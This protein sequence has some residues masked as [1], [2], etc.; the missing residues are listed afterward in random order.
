M[1]TFNPSLIYRND[2]LLGKYEYNIVQVINSKFGFV[3]SFVGTVKYI[4]LEGDFYYIDSNSDNEDFVPLNNNDV[5]STYIDTLVRVTGVIAQDYA[6]IY[7]FGTHI[8]ILSI[9]LEH[10]LPSG[11]V[12]E[13]I[14]SRKYAVYVPTN[15]SETNEN[16]PLLMNFHGYDDEIENYINTSN[17]VSLSEIHNFILVYP[18]G[19]KDESGKYHWNSSPLGDNNKSDSDDL[20]FFDAVVA[21]VSK[22]YNIDMKRIYA[23]GFSNGGGFVHHLARN[24]KIAAGVCVSGFSSPQVNNPSSSVSFMT[25]HGTSDSVVPYNGSEYYESMSDVLTYWSNHNNTVDSTETAIGNFTHY[26]YTSGDNNT[27]VEHYK[28]N[29]GGHVWDFSKYDFD[30]NTTVVEFLLQYNTDGAINPPQYDAIISGAG[31]GGIMAAVKMKINDPNLNVLVLEQNRHT[32]EEYKAKSYDLLSNWQNAMNDSEFMRAEQSTDQKTLWVGEGNGGGTLHFGLQYIDQTDI[33]NQRYSN[34]QPYF[35]EV[36]NITNAQTYNYDDTSINQNWKELKT[37]LENESGFTTYN[38][39]IYSSDAGNAKVNRLLLGD[40]LEQYGIGIKYNCSVS[41]LNTTNNIVSSVVTDKGT[42]FADKFILASGALETPKILLRS[43]I[44]TD[45]G[46]SLYDHAGCTF[47]YAKPVVTQNTTTF[48]LND[49]AITIIKQNSGRLVSYVPDTRLPVDDQNKVWDFTGFASAHPGGN[50]FKSNTVQMNLS[51]NENNWNKA[52]NNDGSNSVTFV[53][54]YNQVMYYDDLPNNLKSDALAIALG[55]SS[56]TY[57]DLGLEP[58]N[59]IGHIQTRDPGYKWQTYYSLIPNTYDVEPNENQILIVTHAQCTDLGGSGNLNLTE[60]NLNHSTA[61]G[62]TIVSHIADAYNKNNAILNNLGYVCLEAQETGFDLN[63]FIN[64]NLNSIYHYHGTCKDIVNVDHKVNN[65]DNLYIGDA[66]VLHSPWGGSTSVPSAVAGYIAGNIASGGNRA[67]VPI[68]S[69]FRISTSVDYHE[70]Y[71]NDVIELTNTI[72]NH[73]VDKWRSVITEKVFSNKDSDLNLKLKFND[74]DPSQPLLL[75]SA[76][77]TPYRDGYYYYDE[78]NNN[79]YDPG[80]EIEGDLDVADNGKIMVFRGTLDFFRGTWTPQLSEIKNNGKTQAYYTILHEIGHILGIGLIWETDYHQFTETVG[81]TK[82]YTGIHGNNEYKA[83]VDPDGSKNIQKIPIENDGGD[84]TADGHIEEGYI[85][86]LTNNN[87]RY[88]GSGFVH[89]GLEHELMTGWAES[90][91]IPEPLSRVTVGLL[92]DLGYTVNYDAADEYTLPQTHR[93]YVKS[94]GLSYEFYTDSML[95]NMIAK[96]GTNDANIIA[97]IIANLGDTIE[98]YLIGVSEYHP[99]IINNVMVGG[100]TSGNVKFTM[101]NESYTYIC[102]NHSSMN[103]KI[104]T[105][106]ANA[107]LNRWKINN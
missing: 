84:G 51:H 42:Y 94:N 6:S 55:I 36:A 5:L 4:S 20:G 40:L 45:V 91:T 47:T 18:Q 78:N 24:N 63:T 19:S 35:N 68:N 15:Y 13:Y 53:G 10:S 25:I 73:A 29:D 46:T 80:E 74:T 30:T 77:V 95:S 48:T 81:N 22:M 88:E 75:G 23:C 97:N 34:W 49:S 93:Y 66:S 38:N 107:K 86:G 89:P 96:T 58:N 32:L 3:E 1:K 44:T 69:N 27:S 83:I 9:D 72:I 16:V 106:E 57:E 41:V 7:M 76:S 37:A 100:Q 33:I 14:E 103:G 71:P 50:V 82:W 54:N 104:L 56:I 61:S 62:Q 87:R 90:S 85:P 60:I 99:F 92:Q 64:A 59:Y 2:I 67:Q 31:P 8:H 21:Q 11:F 28:I 70:T 101:N 79:Q 102:L 39:K 105:R 26:V 98:I 43:G 17:L 52:K 65:Y 12:V